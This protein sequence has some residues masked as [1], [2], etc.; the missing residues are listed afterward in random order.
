[1]ALDIRNSYSVFTV[2][3]IAYLP[4]ALVLA[5][6][7]M[8]YD[9]K[10]LKVVL[11]DKKQDFRYPNE[12]IEILWVEELGVPNWRQLAF[13]YDIIEFSTS[14]KAFIAEQLLQDYEKVIF[15]DPD[16]C[17]YSSVDSILKDLESNPILL[18]PHYTTPQPST[19]VESDLAMMRFGSFNLGFF[20][21]SCR[22][23]TL[24]FLR[25]WKQRCVDF[26]FME[27]QF[28]LSTDQ[29]WVAIAPCL[30]E[31]LK[32]S[33]N[34]GYNVAPWNTF[35]RLISKN[36]QGTYQINNR[37]QLVFF[38]FSNFDPQDPQYLNKRASSETGADYPVL[39][40]LANE[41]SDRLIE[42]SSKVDA[43]S[44]TFDKMSDG[45]YVSPTL[46][47]AYAA[48]RHELPTEHDPFD[49]MGPVGKFARKNSLIQTKGKIYHYP[50]LRD[51]QKYPTV[52]KLI[53]TALRIILWLVGPNKF[54]NLSKLFVFLSIYR[55]NRQLW[56]L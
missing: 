39:Q 15:L 13:M 20:A 30:F 37:F 8:N 41:Y 3:N 50:G 2:C 6:S 29:K 34:L 40:E 47:R 10:K 36:I 14:L 55:L 1:M 21:V 17:L 28:G 51:K 24:E 56:K 23:E 9:Q 53:Y 38:H 44:Y 48:I 11:F 52:L 18:T 35:E 32:V 16:T 31:S 27:S 54:Y 25:W 4:K 42:Y 43:V 19:D 49:S 5:N 22:K 45:S 33:F 26:C 46:R 12:M 7:L